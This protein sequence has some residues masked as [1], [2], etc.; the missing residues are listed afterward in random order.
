M[1]LPKK[2]GHV[3]AP[4]IVAATLQGCAVNQPVS[5]DADV[6]DMNLSTLGTDNANTQAQIPQGAVQNTNYAQSNCNNEQNARLTPQFLNTLRVLKTKEQP[7]LHLNTDRLL[8]TDAE[9]KTGKHNL[10][11]FCNSEYFSALMEFRDSLNIGITYHQMKQQNGQCLYSDDNLAL[12]TEIYKVN[13][14]IRISCLP[15]MNDK[16]EQKEQ[17]APQPQ[18]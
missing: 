5:L 4:V 3:F 14:D 15:Y 10:E 6:S 13:E 8:G 9:Y 17:A 1:A 18:Q 12:A 11:D 16:Q 7:Y 2:L